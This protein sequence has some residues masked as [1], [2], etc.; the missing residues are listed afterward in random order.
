MKQTRPTIYLDHSATTPVRPEV[1]AAMQPYFSELY[2]NP[3]SIHSVG[4]RAGVALAQA[5]RT[6]ADL[7]HAKPNEIIFTS[8]GSEGD[9]AALRGIALAR[10]E[11]TGANRVITSAIEHHAVLHTAE[12]LHN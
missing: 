4:R 12:D 10:R 2:G 3:S 8:G 9:N 7:L 1:W 11:A 5:R 6:I